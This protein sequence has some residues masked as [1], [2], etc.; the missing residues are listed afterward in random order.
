MSKRSWILAALLW[1]P[2]AL[3]QESSTA[4]GV[5]HPSDAID[6]SD[7]FQQKSIGSKT[8]MAVPDVADRGAVQAPGRRELVGRVV[9]AEPGRVWV[10]YQGAMVSLAV[11]P[12]TRFEGKAGAKTD[13]IA[14]GQEVRA[15]FDVSNGQNV[16]TDVNLTARPAATPASPTRGRP[17]QRDPID[18]ELRNPSL[19]PSTGESKGPASPMQEIP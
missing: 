1:T 3:A 8:P 2:V 15:R 13:A 10:D 9:R 11:T 7:A 5:V 12:Q 16:A 6:N 19:V 14:P 18:T 17:Q 4:S